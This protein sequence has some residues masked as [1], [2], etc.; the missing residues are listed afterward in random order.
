M[1]NTNAKCP[2]CSKD[3]KVVLDISNTDF[4]AEDLKDIEIETRE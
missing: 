4:D 3:I 1:K 2:Y